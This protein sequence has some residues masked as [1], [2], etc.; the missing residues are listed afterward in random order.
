MKTPPHLIAALLH[1]EDASFYKHSGVN[2][3][4]FGRA[5]LANLQ[6]GTYAQ[7]AS[8]ITM[9]VVRNLTQDKEKNLK[10]KCVKSFNLYC[11]S[12]TSVKVRSYNFY[13]DMPYLG[14]DGYILSAV[15]QQH[16]SFTSKGHTG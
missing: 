8:T 3:I 2:F 7:G 12:D 14:Q 10:R 13:L 16:L 9:Q 6:G 4:A 15:L 5:V 11:S 1:S